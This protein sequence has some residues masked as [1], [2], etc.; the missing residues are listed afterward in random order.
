MKL[1]KLPW[2]GGCRCGRLRFRLIQPPM[3]TMVCH[4]KGCQLMTGSAFSTS[5]II[6]AHG[7]ALIAGEPAIGGLHGDQARHHHCDW[8]KSWVFTRIEPD[9]GFI[10]VRATMLDNAGWFIPFVETFTSEAL[11]WVRTPAIHS[12]S[13]FPKL[14]EFTSLV[15]EFASN[16]TSTA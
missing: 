14:E 4:C 2:E 11:A 15:A 6:P 5:V 12:Y 13:H 8:C 9:L 1:P 10:N 3:L 7:F 16:V